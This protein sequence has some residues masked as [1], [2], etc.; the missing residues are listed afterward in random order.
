MYSKL[1]EIET[2]P[3]SE[4]PVIDFTQSEAGLYDVTSQGCRESPNFICN[5]KFSIEAYCRVLLTKVFSINIRN[6]LPFLEYQCHN[7][8]APLDWLD[9]LETLLDL[10]SDHLFND[11]LKSRSDKI[12]MNIMICRDNLSHTSNPLVTQ[13]NNLS[14][15]LHPDEF[16]KFNFCL[17][18]LDLAKLN[19]FNEQKT[20]LIEVRADFQETQIIC[21]LSSNKDFETLIDIEMN[22][23]EKL[24]SIPETLHFPQVSTEK[25]NNLVQVNG[26]I[27]I[28][29][30]AFYQLMQVKVDG[31]PYIDSTMTSV[32]NM[33]VENFVNQK[34]ERVPLSTVKSILSPG[35]V[36]KRPSCDKRYCV[37]HLLNFSLLFCMMYLF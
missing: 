16:G 30:D 10:N 8:N 12:C 28:L 6:I 36:E 7:L 11:S 1:L 35:K 15:K 17:V 24:M 29:V 3:F 14:A 33:I 18:K 25:N 23:L 13:F 22:K 2:V 32:A 34:G 21:P 31:K 37:K 19:S 20:H 5:N 27:N 9:Q 4:H 26:N